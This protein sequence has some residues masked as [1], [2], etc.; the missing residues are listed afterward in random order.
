MPVFSLATGFISISLIQTASITMLR[1]RAPIIMIYY[2]ITKALRPGPCMT[3]NIHI[4]LLSVDREL[5]G[6]RNQITI[7]R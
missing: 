1:T 4:E 3:D 6:L 2:L 7:N 5:S